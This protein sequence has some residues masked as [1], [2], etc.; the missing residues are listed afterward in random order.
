MQI[1]LRQFSPRSVAWLRE[2]AASEKHSRSSLARGLCEIENW[3]NSAGEPCLASARKVLPRLADKLGLV[4]P[5]PLRRPN[6]RPPEAYPDVALSCGLQELGDVRAEPV[7]PKDVTPWRS[8]MASHHPQ[9]ERR[10]PGARLLYWIVSSRRGRLGG[11]S[12]CAAGWHQRARDSYIGWTRRELAAHL[13]RVVN[14]A[15]FLILPG[16]RVPSLASRALGLALSRL[17]DDWQ[18]AYGVRP[19]LAYTYVDAGQ[20]GTCY[21]AAGWER[22]EETTIRGRSVWMRPLCADWRQALRAPT[23]RELGTAPPLSETE[24]WAAME[25]GRSSIPDGRL[26]TRLVYMGRQWEESPGA[27]VDAIFPQRAERTAA[28]RFLSNQ[29]VTMDDILEPHREALTERCRQERTVLVAHG[30]VMLNHVSRRDRT[31]GF[32]VGGVRASLALTEGGRPLGVLALDADSRKPA[33]E[34]SEIPEEN[35]GKRWLAGLAA[36]KELGRACRG[37]RVISVCDPVADIYGLFEAQAAAP[38]EAGLLVRVGRDHH[39]HRVANG[40]AAPGLREYME[41][42]SPCAARDGRHARGKRAARIELRIAR[43]ALRA[44]GASGETLEATA[45][46]ATEPSSQRNGRAPSLM[47]LCTEGGATSENALRILAWYERRREMEDFF[48]IFRTGTRIGDPALGN[49]DEL[50]RCLAFDAIAAW[51]AFDR[52]RLVW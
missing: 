5:A 8:M 52:G 35:E 9:G 20:T 31:G 12:F 15:R 41:G 13:G 23:C 14:N 38:D 33:G 6:V 36:A 46:R 30:A 21:A 51:R 47:L 3:R 18:A 26:R 7:A 29:Q 27:P 39:G 16:V 42:H 11:L 22:C 44:P 10:Q 25:Y 37:R 48:R 24:D 1:G 17:A 40:D 43:I 32:A 19:V 49:A 4:L 34:S 28:Y 50:K 45:V 2:A